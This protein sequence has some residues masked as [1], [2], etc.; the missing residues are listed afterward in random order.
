MAP[1]LRL[2]CD[3]L[4]QPGKSAVT[5]AVLWQGHVTGPPVGP[6]NRTPTIRYHQR[7]VALVFLDLVVMRYL[8]TICLLVVVVHQGSTLAEADSPQPRS[9]DAGTLSAHEFKIVFDSDFS[10]PD[11]LS[12]GNYWRRET[13]RDSNNSGQHRQDVGRRHAA[14]YDK[15]LDKTAFIRDGLLVQR[16]FVADK[17]F[18]G[19]VS[20]DADGPRDIKY[21]DPDPNEAGKGTVNFADFELHTSW[22]DTFAVKSVD[23]Q[24]VPV[25]RTDEVVSKKEFWGQP[26]KSDTAS[27]NIV[28]SPGSYF[29]IDVNF[30]NMNAVAHRHSFWLMPAVD[31]KNA[32][33]K[34]PANG[35][36]IDIYEHELA[37]APDRVDAQSARRNEILL[38]KCIGGS[39]TPPSTKNELRDDANTAIHIP[40]INVGWHTIGLLWATDRLTW[41]VDGHP[42][43]QDSVLIPQVD[44]FLILSREGNTGANHSGRPEHVKANPPSIPYDAGLFGGNVATPANRNVIKAHQDDVLIRS[45]RAWRVK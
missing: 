1:L 24:Q 29:E 8:S 33:D 45:V 44:M 40:G 17:D 9:P 23:G 31:Q 39:T 12:G 38:M 15:Y 11:V 22:F 32:Y 18:D 26:G 28:F 36:E 10:K 43:V 3:F 42:V 41:F 30:E 37:V 13:M 34:D 25:L 19:F 35:L 21:T 4:F 5:E 16:G 27:P 2:R 6:S 14:W 20:R 7:T